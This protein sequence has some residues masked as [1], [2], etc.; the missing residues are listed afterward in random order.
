MKVIKL[1]T[2]RS[3]CD[4]LIFLISIAN[5]A[6]S[7]RLLFPGE[8]GISLKLGIVEPTCVIT[9][10]KDVN[11]IFGRSVSTLTV[12]LDSAELRIEIALPFKFFTIFAILR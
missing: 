8:T 6:F 9:R 4:L 11:S 7:D 3:E 5:S 1:R 2:A 12:A 10:N